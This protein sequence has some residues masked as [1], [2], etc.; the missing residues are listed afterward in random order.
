MLFIYVCYATKE[1]QEILEIW[2]EPLFYRKKQRNNHFYLGSLSWTH[3]ER[4][5]ISQVVWDSYL[6]NK[7]IS[8]NLDSPWGH[9]SITAT[10]EQNQY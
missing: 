2:A 5:P 7:P 10:S 4:S 3:Q 6:N 8:I 1:K 9:F